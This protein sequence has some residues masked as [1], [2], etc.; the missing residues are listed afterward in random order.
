MPHESPAPPARVERGDVIG[1]RELSAWQTAPGVTWIQTRS[2]EYARKLARRSDAR[3]VA[4][5]V[6]GGF[7]RTFIFEHSRAWAKKLLARYT[8]NEG[9]TN[10]VKTAPASPDANDS[11]ASGTD[12]PGRT[13]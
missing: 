6:D 11:P 5:G 3:L 8:Q 4:V 7:L 9:C 12:A 2:P 1:T 10:C 13:P